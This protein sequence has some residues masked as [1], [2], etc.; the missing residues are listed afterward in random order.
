MEQGVPMTEARQ[1]SSEALTREDCQRLLE[2]E[3]PQHII[4]GKYSLS[5]SDFYLKLKEWGL[6]RKAANWD[7]RSERNKKA[8]KEVRDT[9]DDPGPAI[10]GT[11]T[12][13][14]LATK[15][16]DVGPQ[17]DAP[18]LI[19][20]DLTRKKAAELLASGA[21]KQQIKRLYN[22][23]NDPS[24]YLKLQTFGLHERKHAHDCKTDPEE[25]IRVAQVVLR[26][27]EQEEA[28]SAPDPVTEQLHELTEEEKQ[29]LFAEPEPVPQQP[30]GNATTA[31]DSL[32]EAYLNDGIFKIQP[33]SDSDLK[34]LMHGRVPLSEIDADLELTGDGQGIALLPISEAVVQAAQFGEI[35]IQTTER[36]TP[37][38]TFDLSA[39]RRF[40][41]GMTRTR[42]PNML[43]TMSA[44]GTIRLCSGLIFSSPKE[45]QGQD[46]KFSAGIYLS[47]DGRQIIIKPEDGGYGFNSFKE[48]SMKKCSALPAVQYIGSKTQLPAAYQTEWNTELC[49]WVGRLIEQRESEAV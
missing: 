39:M 5:T 48:S 33:I 10:E 35:K 42:K 29:D 43:I 7:F 12:V 4:A 41:P 38:P 25:T 32:E 40:A 15:Y 28:Q 14:E 19:P 37:P 49:A 26:E 31:L 16:Q 34:D 44:K 20:A 13:A 9:P 46:V 6:N 30:Q 11:E 27:I 1:M 36:P 22:F 8:P 47:D 18:Q 17:A 3:Y 21:T 2:A 45:Y 23:K 24:L